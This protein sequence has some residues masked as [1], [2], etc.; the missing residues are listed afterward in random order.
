MTGIHYR[1]PA[2]LANM[3][4]D[5]RHRL[6]RKARAGPRGRVERGGVRRL[7]HRPRDA[8][9][10]SDR[11]DEA[12]EVI[13]RPAH[14][15]DDLVQGHLL[16][17][18]RRPLQPEAAAA[19]SSAD[20]RRRQRRTAHAAHRRPLRPA[21]ELPRR[22]G[23]GLRPQARR[24][25]RALRRARPGSVEILLSSHVRFEGDPSA[26]AA[27]AAALADA[28]AGLAIVQLRRRTPRRCS[29]HLRRHWP[30]SAEPWRTG[31]G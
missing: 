14:E 8:K 9:Q 10:R 7:R 2:V 24:A 11:F 27:A 4:A 6:G 1:H 16:R 22:P 12:C 28:G 18:D 5:A 30:G 13:D 17:A 3:A 29:S 26:T 21:L 19:S 31:I 15:R 20:L 25:A 23:G